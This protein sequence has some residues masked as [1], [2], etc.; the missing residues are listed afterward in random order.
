MGSQYGYIF[1]FADGRDVLTFPITPGELTYKQGSK[2]ET[3][4]LISEGEVNIP[5]PPSLF[6]I[7]FEARFP[8]V[9]YPYSRD[10]WD[11]ES[12]VAKFEELKNEKKHFHFIV[13]RDSLRNKRSWE[14]D[15][16]VLLEDFTINE[17]ADEGD[18][19]LISFKLKQYKEYGVKKVKV[20]IDNSKPTTTSTSKE[21][22]D[23]DNKASETKTY[24]VKSGDTL[25]TIAKGEYGNG[26]LHSKIYDANVNAIEADAQKHGKESS[27]NGH[28][29][30]PD[31]VLTIPA[32]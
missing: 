8:M 26:S 16:K 22:R 5:K 10:A 25:W 21:P 19:V 31:L 32:K 2:N 3:I 4:T 29:I 14:T 24:T 7:E 30:Y 13:I 18:D 20:E 15:V 28:W 12:Y 17:K 1:Y 11:F 6:E 27:R 23:T 9:K